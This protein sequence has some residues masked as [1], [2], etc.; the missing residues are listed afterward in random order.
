MNFL[1]MSRLQGRGFV[2]KSTCS[3]LT[4]D[5][6]STCS[7]ILDNYLAVQKAFNFSK[8]TWKG[9]CTDAVNG[10]WCDDTRKKEILA[11]LDEV[12]TEWADKDL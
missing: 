5:P 2:R 8:D 12:M 9:L 10:S 7:Y 6:L 4:S 3:A 11:K 1:A